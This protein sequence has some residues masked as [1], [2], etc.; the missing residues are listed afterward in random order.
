MADLFDEIVYCSKCGRKMDKV[1]VNRAGF[2]IRA[3]ECKRCS[4]YIYHPVDIEEYRKFRELKQRPF[5][6]KLRMVGNSYTVSIPKEIIE[7]ER[8]MHKEMA[9]QMAKM[10]KIVKLMLE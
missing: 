8:E 7:L 6:V 2:Q 4:K 10:N 9:R 3:L 5:R 1:I